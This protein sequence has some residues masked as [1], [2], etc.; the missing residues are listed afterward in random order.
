[1]RK[2]ESSF[3]QVLTVE[4]DPSIYKAAKTLFEVTES[5]IISKFGNS[6]DF[7]KDIEISVGNKA[8]IFMDAHYSTGITSKEF[9]TCPILEEISVILERFPNA[10]CVIDDI[11]CMNGQGG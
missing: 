1:V 2:V 11:R 10:L 7:L 4:A 5:K 9:G 8:V 6:V 3:S